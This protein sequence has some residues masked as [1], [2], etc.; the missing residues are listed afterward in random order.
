MITEHNTHTASTWDGLSTTPDHV[1]EALRL[2]SQIL[3]LVQAGIGS[4]FVFK[5]TITSK[6]D[7]VIKKNG[8]VWCE[9][10]VDPYPLSDTTLSAEAVRLFSKTVNSDI[11][12]VT[13]NSIDKS[14][15]YLA[16]VNSDGFCYLYIVNE[17]ASKYKTT[18]DLTNFGKSFNQA[19][20]HVVETVGTG[21][22][23][24]ISSIQTGILFTLNVDAYSVHRVAVQKGSQSS[25]VINA[26][27]ACTVYAGS[28]SSIANCGNP[29]I[30]ISTS[31]TVQH[32]STAV[33]LIQFKISPNS[34]R[35]KRTLLKINVNKISGNFVNNMTVMILG[36]NS[37]FAALNNP[38]WTSLSSN[39]VGSDLLNARPSGVVINTISQNFINWPSSTNPV[40]AGHVTANADSPG[41]DRIIDVTEYADKIYKS[42]GSMLSFVLYRPFRHPAY[43]NTLVPISGDDLSKGATMVISS[44]SNCNSPP[45]IIQFN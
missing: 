44:S 45:Q 37:N 19:N 22:F 14:V 23:G 13:S 35:A 27:A 11:Y 16:A 2:A 17:G 15:N 8:L 21:F 10:S 41:Q 5:F 6:S 32:E 34:P 33:G 38:T 40:I 9:F 43:T 3:W 42:G 31:N 4:D 29:T 28:K 1:N 18:V 24:E 20:K 7:N 30:S 39:A 12:T 25:S 36:L 26:N